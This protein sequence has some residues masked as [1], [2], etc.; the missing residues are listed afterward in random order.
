MDH[1]HII[2]TANLEEYSDTRESQSVIPELIYLL[3]KASISDGSICRIPYG[4][5][6]NQPGADGLVVSENAFQEFIP[7]GRSYWEIGGWW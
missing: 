4:D 7:Q 2:T 6:V 1:A 5:E 3:V